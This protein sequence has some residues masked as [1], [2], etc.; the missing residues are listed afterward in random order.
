[1]DRL[2]RVFFCILAQF[3][4][5]HVIELSFLNV[6]GI[7]HEIIVSVILVVCRN[8]IVAIV[9]WELAF[10]VTQAYLSHQLRLDIVVRRRVGAKLPGLV[11]IDK[12]L[13]LVQAVVAVILDHLILHRLYQL[14]C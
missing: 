11:T 13:V 10:T 12:C 7:T 1:V 6:L 3:R 8:T 2:D 14:V 4:A 5:A 9:Y